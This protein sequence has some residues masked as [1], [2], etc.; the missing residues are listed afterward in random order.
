MEYQD[1]R[2][3]FS[4]AR[5]QHNIMVLV[6]NGFDIKVLEQYHKLTT[7][8]EK[9]YDYYMYHSNSECKNILVNEMT[10]LKKIGQILKILYRIF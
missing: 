4:D 6:G 1:L 7:T 3:S 9:F 10:N 5:K 8:Y 2:G